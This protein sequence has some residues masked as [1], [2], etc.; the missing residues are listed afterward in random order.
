MPCRWLIP[1]SA[2]AMGVVLALVWC[3]AC[4]AVEERDGAGSDRGQPTTLTTEV[5]SQRMRDLTV[6]SDALGR[7]A[8]VRLLLPPGHESRPDGPWPVLYL[9]HGCCDTYESW[10]RS[11]DVEELTEH[12]ELIVVMPDGGRA[13]FYSDWLD[14][15]RW[16]TFH[17]TELGG[18][19]EGSYGAGPRRA[20][21]GVSMGGLGALAYTAR[22]PGM[23]QA[24]ASFSGIVNTRASPGAYLRLLRG[25]G[26]QPER[27]WGDPSKQA[28]VWAAHN[29]YDLA[30]KLQGTLLFL[31]V[32]NGQP[33][34]LDPP[35]SAVDP[36]EASLAS[37]NIALADRLRELNIPAQTDFYGPGT[38]T[39]PYWQREL[40]LAWPM[41][42]QSLGL[43]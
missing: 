13:G 39:W 16:E 27:L 38:H 43:I 28:D 42:Q 21:V 36:I 12:S 31:S 1:R 18:I 10:T 6:E 37:D 15:P 7:K 4:D 33:G 32:G 20:I 40:H 14:G 5:L 30:P 23:F 2:A 17:L 24:A 9:L 41:I 35:G 29:P 22:N 19:L 25:E 8:R 34:P 26:E 11:T 3:A